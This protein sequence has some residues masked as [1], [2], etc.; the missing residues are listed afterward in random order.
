VYG[1][2]VAERKTIQEEWE[3]G[4]GEA[5]GKHCRTVRAV[6]LYSLITVVG[7]YNPILGEHKVDRATGFPPLEVQSY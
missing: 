6:D 2:E 1:V 5:V 4:G 7:G 3:Q